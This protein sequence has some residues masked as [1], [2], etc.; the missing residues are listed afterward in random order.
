MSRVTMLKG[1]S[2]KNGV[3]V[4]NADGTYHTPGCGL[5]EGEDVRTKEELD[6]MGDKVP[7]EECIG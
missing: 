2:S 7:C 1:K 4:L 3:F 5:R 6:E